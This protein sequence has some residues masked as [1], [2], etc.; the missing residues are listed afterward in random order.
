[1]GFHVGGSLQ[2][3]TV[4]SE[5]AIA[6]KIDSWYVSGLSNGDT[7]T[8]NTAGDGINTFSRVSVIFLASRSD[9]GT[10]N[11]Y[12]YGRDKTTDDWQVIYSQTGLSEGTYVIN[13]N[14]PPKK[15]IYCYGSAH[16]RTYPFYAYIKGLVLP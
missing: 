7:I 8:T 15:Y 5:S 12:V 3:S 1:M 2:L 14:V 4:R 11:F 9:P 13:Q 6:K 10:C 16:L